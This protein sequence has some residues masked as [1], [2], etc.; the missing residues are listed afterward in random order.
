M[1]CHIAG[2]NRE[3]GLMQYGDGKPESVMSFVGDGMRVF[4]VYIVRNP[5]KLKDISA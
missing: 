2:I 4:D 5:E 3:S 1:T